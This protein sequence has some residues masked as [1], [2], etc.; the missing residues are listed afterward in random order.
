MKSSQIPKTQNENSTLKVQ[1][2][3]QKDGSFLQLEKKKK[4]QKLKKKKDR[5]R[6]SE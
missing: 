6:E 2:I 5:E 3:Q 4:K 1:F